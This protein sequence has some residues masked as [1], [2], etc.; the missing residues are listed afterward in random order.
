MNW[1]V[2]RLQNEHRRLN[3]L[4]DDRRDTL[5]QNELALLKRLRLRVKDRLT[6]LQRRPA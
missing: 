1:Y 6:E 4:I 2:S 5:G 3:R